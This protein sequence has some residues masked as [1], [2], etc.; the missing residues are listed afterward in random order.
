MLELGVPPLG[1]RIGELEA[2]L[3][4]ERHERS[5]RAVGRGRN[6]SGLGLGLGLS[7]DVR[8]CRYRNRL[9]L[10][11]GR[12]RALDHVEELFRGL[13]WIQ[14]GFDPQLSEE[15]ADAPDRL[16]RRLR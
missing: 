1:A 12:F 14:P 4:S 11:P 5:A 2:L 6:R 13:Q 16:A 9:R 7:R 15:C 10:G 8:R 3:M